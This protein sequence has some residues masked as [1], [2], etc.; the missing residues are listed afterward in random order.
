MEYSFIEILIKF[1][2]FCVGVFILDFK[3]IIIEQIG[4]I[5]FGTR[6]GWGYLLNHRVVLILY[7]W[8]LSFEWDLRYGVEWPEELPLDGV[9]PPPRRLGVISGVLSIQ[10]KRINEIIKIWM[11]KN[12]NTRSIDGP[13]DFPFV[14]ILFNSLL[15]R[16]PIT[17]IFF[18]RFTCS[19]QR[20]HISTIINTLQNRRGIPRFRSSMMASMLSSVLMNSLFNWTV[21]STSVWRSF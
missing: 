14:V 19:I 15:D 2:I 16:F 4:Q 7:T 9:W 13:R 17:F 1:V 18:R 12:S 8:E 3:I 6:W 21:Q 10:I 5:G 11:K 20:I